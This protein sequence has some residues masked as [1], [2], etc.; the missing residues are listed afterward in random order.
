M[1]EPTQAIANMDY[2]GYTSAS[3]GD[4]VLDYIFDQYDVRA[5]EEEYPDEEYVEYDLTYFFENTLE[6]YDVE[7]AV[8]HVW[9]KDTEATKKTYEEE[10]LVDETPYAVYARM[11]PAQFPEKSMLPRLCVMDDYGKQNEKVLDMWQSVRTNP[12]PVWAIVLFA[13]EAALGAFFI[14]YLIT[15]KHIQKKLRY[16]YRSK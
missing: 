3:A 6:T 8:L 11:M 5:A 14:I 13:I 12:L 10:E 9:T 4:D 16:E 7:D 1:S 15:K 2:V